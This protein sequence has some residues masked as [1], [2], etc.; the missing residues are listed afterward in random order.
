[1]S[2]HILEV[3]PTQ[4]K[5]RSHV[6]AKYLC[7]ACRTLVA[8]PRPAKP[9]PNSYVGSSLLAFVIG[10]QSCYHLSFYRMPKM[11][12]R[13]GHPADRSL[14]LAESFAEYRVAYTIAAFA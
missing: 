5:V 4:L 8:T 9:I 3:V 6:R 14:V 13:L 12:A 7:D 10:S 11:L 1:M 2:R